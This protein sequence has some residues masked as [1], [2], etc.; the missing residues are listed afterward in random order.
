MG[1][2]YSVSVALTGYS[3]KERYP[4]RCPADSFNAGSVKF[5]ASDKMAEQLLM[6]WTSRWIPQRGQ[7]HRLPTFSS[8]A[9]SSVAQF[10][11]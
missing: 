6:R 10:P 7:I 5:S 4:K 1:P 9:A 11:E 8:E 2:A 3:I